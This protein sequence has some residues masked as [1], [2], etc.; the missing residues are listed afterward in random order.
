MNAEV[1]DDSIGVQL[2]RKR[3]GMFIGALDYR[4][5]SALLY[6]CIA[7]LY[8]QASCKAIIFSFSITGPYSF[9]IATQGSFEALNMDYS[10]RLSVSLS[11]FETLFAL[12]EKAELHTQRGTFSIE[13]GMPRSKDKIASNGFS[14]KCVLDTTIFKKE[15]IR[16]SHLLE[17]FR[18]L[19]MLNPGLEMI[20]RDETTKHLRQDWFCFPLGLK[21]M[22]T[23]IVSGAKEGVFFEHVEER[24]GKRYRVFFA[25]NGDWYSR[26]PQIIS[27][28]GIKRTSEHG[29]L[30]DGVL[31]AF[32]AAARLSVS[33]EEAREFI[34]SVGRLRK[35][36]NLVLV[37]SVENIDAKD[38]GFD[39]AGATKEKLWD[40]AIKRD[41]RKVLLPVFTDLFKKD[42]TLELHVANAFRNWAAFE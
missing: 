34:F 2:I 29:S 26:G 6:R 7:E 32:T 30:V 3:P 33:G 39:Y 10:E 20:V 18:Q 27:F 40:P 31:S 22:F 16:Y 42:N 36:H 21:H 23:D 24:N 28:A 8:F 37:T 38:Q 9:Q 11:D 15:T 13:N 1:H 25:L 35:Y 17:Q 4:G 14:L 12:C 41:I 5:V 19:C